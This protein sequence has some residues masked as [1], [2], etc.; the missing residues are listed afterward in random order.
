MAA[1]RVG[2]HLRQAAASDD[3]AQHGD[4][5]HERGPL[6]GAGDG[7]GQ[8]PL[9]DVGPVLDDVAAT[10][11]EAAE[12]A[13]QRQRRVGD[14]LGRREAAQAG[15]Q[16]HRPPLQRG[17]GGVGPQQAP[18]ATDVTGGRRV[19]GGARRVAVGLEPRRRTPIASALVIMAGP[20]Q[21]AAQQR[22]QQWM[23]AEGL[24][25]A[26][27]RVDED[28][29]ARQLAQGRSGSL[30]AGHGIAQRAGQLVQ[31][32]GA[33]QELAVLLGQVLQEHVAQVVGDDPVLTPE[34]IDGRGAPAGAANRQGGQRQARGPALGR[35]HHPAQL[36]GVE[37]DA[38]ALQQ[39]L[40]FDGR[41]GQ[42]GGAHLAHA[43]L[44]AQPADRQRRLAR[45]GDGQDRSRRKLLGRDQHDLARPRRERFGVVE[46][47]SDR[48][49]RS[50]VRAPP[51]RLQQ[52][53]RGRVLGSERDPLARTRITVG[54]LPQE[55]RLAVARRRHHEADARACLGGE[56]AGEVRTRHQPPDAQRCDGEVIGQRCE[57]EDDAT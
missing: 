15:L 45:R 32:R 1:A 37:Q 22:P 29:R 33:H 7:A 12:R 34:A 51:D 20:A 39:L 18:G 21:V 52:P 38:R 55:R 27:E 49:R 43:R 13:A 56:P 53:D 50:R 48:S 3:R 10:V 57:H 4:P 31:H 17:A 6:V 14:G 24:L 36:G 23:H 35:L 11:D 8:R 41:H 9:A 30:A 5:R 28:V 2:A 26:S 44:E 42:V 47:D 25:V 16:A 40:A 19:R 46:H 54:P